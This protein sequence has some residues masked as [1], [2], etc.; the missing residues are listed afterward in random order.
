MAANTGPDSNKYIIPE[1]ELADT[2]NVWRDTT[3][4][5]SYKLNKIKVYDGISSSTIG[6][7]VATGGTF[8]ANLLDTINQGMT[9]NQPVVFSSGVTFN[10]D[11]TF[12]AQTFTVNANNVTIDDF[13]VLLGATTGSS[14]T[15][16]NNAGGGGI[17]ISRGIGSTADWL[18]RATQ[19]QGLTGIWNSNAHIGLCGASAGLYPHNGAVLPIHGTGFRLDGNQSG[20]HGVQ[21]DLTN[22][23]G[24]NSVITLSRYSPSGSTAF[25]E[26]LNG[27]TYGTRPFVNIKDGANRKTI[28]QVNH[29]FAVG[30]PVRL[31]SNGTYTEARADNAENAEVVGLV[32]AKNGA[33]EFELTFIGEI[34]GNFSQVVENG[35]NLVAGQTYYL[36]PTAAGKLTPVQ[37]TSAGMVH[38]AVLI[39]TSTTSGVVLP[40]TGGLLTSALAVSSTSSV[41]TRIRQANQFKIGDIVRFRK[42]DVNGITLSYSIGG[43][44]VERWYQHG[45]YVKAQANSA[46]E[47]TV[48]GMVVGKDAIIK[49]SNYDSN[50][51]DA[52]WGEF[53]VLMDGWF[54]GLSEL[55]PGTEYWLG[56]NVAGS[57]PN[58]ALESGANS[59]VVQSPG[60]GSQVSKKLFMATSPTSGYL[61]SYRGDVNQPPTTEVVTLQNSLIT[62]LRS[63]ENNDLSIGVYNGQ[64]FGYRS[65]TVATTP[66]NSVGVGSTMGNVGMGEITWSLYKSTGDGNRILAPLDVAGWTRVGRAWTGTVPGQDLLVARHS[67]DKAANGLTAESTAI[68]GTEHTTGSLVLGHRVRPSRT[69]AGEYL[70]SLSGQSD[71]SALVLGS[72]TSGNPSLVWRVANDSDVALNSTVALTDVFTIKGNTA[73]FAY[74]LGI[75][76]S[77]PTAK[78]HVS[79]SSGGT[80]LV[81]GGNNSG[82]QFNDSN[83]R[84]TIPSANTLSIFTSNQERLKIDSNGKIIAGVSTLSTDSTKTLTTK[85]YVDGLRVGLGYDQS[86]QSKTITSNT[87]VQNNSAKPIMV[88][89]WVSRSANQYST[90][91]LTASVSTA[92]TGTYTTIA[93]SANTQTTTTSTTHAANVSFIV[94]PYHWY[95]LYSGIGAPA[96]TCVELR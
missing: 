50:P 38:K 67:T 21:V 57:N 26:I 82:I 41:A 87:A 59:Y 86:W 42:A 71:R 29:G 12:N 34:F 94:P 88:S 96:I 35:A 23:T 74:G 76:T 51:N 81:G 6:I 54:D 90:V 85:D 95:K 14:D 63:S 45:T 91:S 22:G 75:G 1:V 77:S 89:A 8:T 7:V 2:F 92:E 68:V 27:A 84:I 33:N 37:P 70:S 49:G 56:I 3:N 16:I 11:V 58:T 62:D 47:A 53:D 28:T 32:S 24:T 17:Q 18:W 15:V 83:T 46:I 39:A 40:F 13:T 4:T 25:A 48:A 31:L 10:G 43:Q 93:F 52:V 20:A 55:A 64:N 61:Y 36:S 60:G 19:L 69:A 79:D 44:V 9:F 80:I 78:L 5:Q 72:D 65:I 30:T 66:T 73:S